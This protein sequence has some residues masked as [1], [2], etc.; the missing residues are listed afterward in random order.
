MVKLP[1]LNDAT[2]WV[3]ASKHQTAEFAYMHAMGNGSAQP[4]ETIADAKENSDGWVRWCFNEA[5]RLKSTGDVYNSFYWFGLGLHTL[6]DA[7]S[8]AHSGFQEWRNDL[9]IIEKW[10]H[11]KVELRYPGEN[12]NLQQ[13][14]DKYLEWF[15][16]TTRDTVDDPTGFSQ[17]NLF[18]GIHPYPKQN[19]PVS[20]YIGIALGYYSIQWIVTALL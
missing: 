12:S 7:T 2:A 5:L 6:Q 20:I 4:K 15:L 3:D 18:D 10:N 14:T 8:P 13:I 17:E 19:V 11:V 16:G 9:S 1:A